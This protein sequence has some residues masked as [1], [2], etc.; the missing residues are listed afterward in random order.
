MAEGL[1]KSMDPGLNV[2]SAGTSPA[3]A[4]HPMAVRVMAEIG[5]DISNAV[6]KDVGKF[7]GESFA[8]VITVCD[9]AKESCPVFL[10]K[11]ACKLH[12]GFKDPAA[13]VGP[14]EEVL[15]A[16]RRVRDDMQRAFREFYSSR[17]AEVA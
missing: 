11:V 4:V 8:Y 2:F 10:G 12:L 15:A 14:E 16:F 13:V 5:L 3:S 6:P 9:N 17:L 7:L 1:L